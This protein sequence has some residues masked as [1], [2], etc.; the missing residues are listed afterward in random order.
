MHG[1]RGPG[2]RADAGLAETTGLARLRSGGPWCARPHVL[3]GVHAPSLEGLV[4]TLRKGPRFLLKHFEEA[5]EMEDCKVRLLSRWHGHARAAGVTVR[6][7]AVSLPLA[8]RS[9]PSP[10]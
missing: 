9:A 1:L 10:R 8:R 4:D 5:V 3:R 6:L 7:T 2:C